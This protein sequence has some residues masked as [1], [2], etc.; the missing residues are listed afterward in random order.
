MG[1]SSGAAEKM[2]DGVT[3]RGLFKGALGALAATVLPRSLARAS[4]APSKAGA[5]RIFRQVLTAASSV[6]RSSGWLK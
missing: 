2:S 6:S 3:R 5:A 1:G 4:G